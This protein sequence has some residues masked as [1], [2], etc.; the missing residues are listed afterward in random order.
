MAQQLPNP[1]SIHEDTGL[2]LASL[3]G[4]KIWH[5]HE[6]WCRSQTWL[7]FCVAVAMALVGG[8][9]SDSTP[10]LGTSIYCRCSPKKIKKKKK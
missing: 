9:S 10:S 7:G 1:T 3:S 2:I 5:R 4:L 8:Y 6:L